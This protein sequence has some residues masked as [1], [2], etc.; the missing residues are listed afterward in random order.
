VCQEQYE[1]S[2]NPALAASIQ[3]QVDALDALHSFPKGILNHSHS[4][5]VF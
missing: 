1:P 3:P 5:T 4:N 2:D